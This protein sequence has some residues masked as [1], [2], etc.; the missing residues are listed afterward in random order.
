MHS[1]SSKGRYDYTFEEQLDS[2]KMKV[3]K[4]GGRQE[5]EAGEEEMTIDRDA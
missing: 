4:K 5:R 3:E 2:G 1:N